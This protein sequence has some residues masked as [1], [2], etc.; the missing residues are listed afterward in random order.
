MCD[1]CVINWG[2]AD[3][4]PLS[5]TSLVVPKQ[6]FYASSSE[7]HFP[8]IRELHYSLQYNFAHFSGQTV[9]PLPLQCFK[10]TEFK[11]FWAIQK[12]L[13]TRHA[14][15]DKLWIHPQVVSLIHQPT[16]CQSIS[17]KNSFWTSFILTIENWKVLRY[18][19][20]LNFIYFEM[21]RNRVEQIIAHWGDHW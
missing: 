6:R 4:I 5:T 10:I 3:S 7:A 9:Q 13:W 14:W 1:T 20:I 21:F 18:F 2:D 19:C 15:L 8:E 17:F 16:V 11:C 12:I